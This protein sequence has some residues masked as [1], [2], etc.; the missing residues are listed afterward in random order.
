MATSTS[1]IQ[2]LV[3]KDLVIHSL[4]AGSIPESYRLK[5]IFHNTPLMIT[6]QLVSGCIC[7]ATTK[8]MP[9]LTLSGLLWIWKMIL[10]GKVYNS[11]F[12]KRI[13][14]MLYQWHLHFRIILPSK[15]YDTFKRMLGKIWF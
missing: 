5:L 9:F 15:L 2:E 3:L 1:Q 10:Q 8:S 4:W 11:I 14:K 13:S 6:G 7:N 12:P